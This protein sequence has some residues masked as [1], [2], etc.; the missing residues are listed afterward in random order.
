[1]GRYYITGLLSS[2]N[3]RIYNNWYIKII[4]IFLLAANLY[5]QGSIS[6]I[7]IGDWGRN[8]DPHQ[9]SVAEQM[10][11]WAM[12]NQAKFVL[13]L[14]DNMYESGVTSTDD[15]QWKTSF[16]DVYTS[17]YLQ[18][19]WYAAL[20]NHDY[21]GNVQA[22]IDYS[23]VSS[24]WK[25]PARYYS[26][27]MKLDDSV[28]VLFVVLDTNPICKSD[29][30]NKSEALK[31][32]SKINNS[33][34][35][36]WLD[37]TLSNT[38][39][40]WKFVSGHHTAI[41]GGYHGGVQE[42]QEQVMPIFEKNKID[43]YFCGHDHDMEYLVENKINYFVSGAGSTT[44]DCENT[45]FTKFYVTK[46][47]GFLGINLSSNQMKATFIDENGTVLYTTTIAK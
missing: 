8:G 16:E 19:P 7:A 17:E 10:S 35:L 37:S 3:N 24:R 38:P 42:M 43:A 22:Q 14:G 34:Q 45:E 26:F 13:S 39:A 46:T 25:M 21:E 32:I 47:S 12:N 33:L 18:V 2:G 15:P 23:N 5:S 9:V 1:M 36:Q 40:K 44:R 29:A 11:A 4:L 20:G 27:T 28:T 30:E 6:F 41:S 31:E